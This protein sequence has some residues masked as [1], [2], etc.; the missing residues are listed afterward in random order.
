M[1]SLLIIA[2]IL[3]HLINVCIS[4]KIFPNSYKCSILTSVPKN[5]S[6]SDWKAVRVV[7]MLS[8]VNK[9]NVIVY[10]LNWAADV[11]MVTDDIVTAL[12]NND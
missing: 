1:Y 5:R 12:V 10:T 9:Y 4:N 2:P 6:Q 7:S 11:V 8:H 3:T